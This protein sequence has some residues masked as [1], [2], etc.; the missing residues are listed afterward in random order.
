MPTDLLEVLRFGVA[1]L[2]GGIVAVIAQRIAFRHAQ[3]LATAEAERQQAASRRALLAEL[4]ENIKALEDRRSSELRRTAW[5]AA[6][7][8]EFRR[9]TLDALV[10]AYL[11]ADR[12]NAGNATLRERFARS[13][14]GTV[15]ILGGGP[16][17]P[18]PVL[19][20]FQKARAEL[21]R[22]V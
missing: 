12:F 1:I 21:Q 8:L 19:E 7:A 14:S 20:L 9:D 15:S 17:D 4:D 3:T 5:D 18:R 13:E 22:E 2:A 16:P 10:A 11:E 6:R